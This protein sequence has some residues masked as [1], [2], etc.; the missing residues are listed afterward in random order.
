MSGYEFE[1]FV[2]DVMK[3]LG[4]GQIEKVLKTQDE[5]RDILIR[6]SA[7]LLVVECKHQPNT[8]IGQP[9]VQ[10]LHSAVIS[11]RAAKGILVTTGR[12]T[13]EAIEYAA[14][15]ADSGTIIEMV[16]RPILGDM[17]SR[18]GIRLISRGESLGVWT[19]SLPSNEQTGDTI[20]AFVS[21]MVQS[22][23]K[24][25]RDYLSRHDRTVTFRPVYLVTYNVNAVFETTVGVIHEERETGAHLIF[26]GNN[27][28]QYTDDVFQ[29]LEKERQSPF[30]GGATNDLD[31]LPRF[32]LDY[33]TLQR[34]ARDAIIRLHTKRIHYR[35]GNNVGYSKECEPGEHDIYISD[36]RQ[37]YLPLVRLDFILSVTSYSIHGVL[38]PSGRLMATSHDLLRC[39]IGNESINK[40]ALLCDVCGRI[41]HSGGL[42]LKNVH[43][44]R[45]NLCKRTTCRHDGYWS[46]RFII[47]RR[48]LCPQ[49]V[50]QVKAG[51]LARN[52]D[53]AK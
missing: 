39:R 47:W 29:F 42:R 6:S 7:G 36:I 10:K 12:F 37:V 5:G 38:A 40:N 35:G 25:P 52:L 41:T 18:A 26:D 49:C 28:Q 34:K 48:L 9:I 11:S 32:R 1:E 22:S 46:R 19:F 20:G 13:K 3:R 50:Q 21:S 30:S 16:D 15:L 44:F 2:A 31:K 8:S 33:V 23:P 43:G 27:G 45:C 24:R 4:Y 17:A 51:Q 53:S 14:R